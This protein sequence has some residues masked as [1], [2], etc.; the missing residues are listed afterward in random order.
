MAVYTNIGE[1]TYIDSTGDKHILYPHTRKEC[2]DGLAEIEDCIG[3]LSKLKTSSKD[4]LVNAINEILV[5][6]NN[7]YNINLY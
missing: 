5:R 1:M 4:S 6:L 3:D 7:K 2:V